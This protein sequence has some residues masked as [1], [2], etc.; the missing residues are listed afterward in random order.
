M[1]VARHGFGVSPRVQAGYGEAMAGIALFDLDRTILGCNSATL[2]VKRQVREGKMSRFDAAKM[3]VMI[4][5][6]Q[7]G[8][9]NVD[10]GVRA[11]I[12]KL[13]GQSEDEIRAETERFWVEEVAH[14]IRPGA[15]AVLDKHRAL[16]EPLYL[17]TGSSTYLSA[18][19]TDALGLDGVI[20]T[21]F[22]VEQGIFTGEGMLCYGPGKVT[23]AEPVLRAANV[24]FEDCA[25]YTDSYTDV[26]VLEL[27]GRPVAVHPDPRLARL[28]RKNG[29]AIE[30]WGEA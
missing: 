4:G 18:C 2:W 26:P 22:E 12:R 10:D 30:D 28:A 1:G 25:F 21:T 29:W 8:T 6:Y 15:A 27:V 23:A 16:G 13:K 24:R 11:A 14:R 5:L 9:G 19:V 7:L 17:L 20:C 3:A